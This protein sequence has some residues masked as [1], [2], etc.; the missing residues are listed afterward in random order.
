M[1][2]LLMS[3][4]V[5]RLL[6]GLFMAGLEVR[7]PDSRAHYFLFRVHLGSAS[8]SCTTSTPP[9]IRGGNLTLMRLGHLQTGLRPVWT[10]KQVTWH[11]NLLHEQP[12][13]T[14]IEP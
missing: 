6:V 9:R 1:H 5:I 13:Y 4:V 8:A 2:L 12:R 11:R 10:V 7:I 14:T 3:V